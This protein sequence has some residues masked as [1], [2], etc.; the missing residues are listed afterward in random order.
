MNN[1][2]QLG[3]GDAGCRAAT[4]CRA[5][6]RNDRR[7]AG[8]EQAFAKNS[9]AN[10]SRRAK[11][12]DFHP[13]RLLLPQVD[14]VRL[15]ASRL[16]VSR[17]RASRFSSLARN[18]LAFAPV[19]NLEFVSGIRREQTGDVAKPLGERRSGQQRV[20]A[21]AQVVVIEVDSEREH[22]DG[23]SVGE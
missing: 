8:I 4:G 9:L 17:Y 21:L 11:Q 20:L 14:Q 1:F 13:G 5:T 22:I 12:K 10:H 6:D 16:R 19:V 7:N 3:I 2:A 18:R 23:E 15:P